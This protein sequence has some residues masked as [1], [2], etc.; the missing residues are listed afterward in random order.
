[1]MNNYAYEKGSDLV[2]YFEM[3]AE[4]NRMKEK[5]RQWKILPDS[6][7]KKSREDTLRQKVV[8]GTIEVNIMTKVDKDQWDKEGNVIPDGYDTLTAL[9][10]YA[11][12]DLDDSSIV[13]SSGMNLRLFH[14]MS[15]FPQFYADVYCVF[16]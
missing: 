7:E 10:D 15:S 1:M 8:P 14:Y 4:E 3:L 11:E 2:K 9:K 13:F 12:S 5:F 6:E 16:D